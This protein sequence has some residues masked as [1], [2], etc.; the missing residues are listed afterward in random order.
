M[1]CPQTEGRFIL[2]C[3]ACDTGIW[4]VL[5][6]VQDNQ[7]KVIAYATR[8]LNKSEKNYCVTDKEL[9]AVR[10]LLTT[11][12]IICWEETSLLGQITRLLNGDKAIF[13]KS[14]ADYLS[15]ARL[16]P[17]LEV[18]GSSLHVAPLGIRSC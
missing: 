5:S 13:L 2:D 10:H 3:D 11:F 8:S 9:L 12:I 17:H 1:S 14:Y 18:H 7:E 6:Q 16:A 15:F 4:T